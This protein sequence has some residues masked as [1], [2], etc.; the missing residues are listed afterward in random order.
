MA[1]DQRL[2]AFADSMGVHIDDGHADYFTQFN[3][4]AGANAFRS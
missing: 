1:D 3:S 4:A 2:D